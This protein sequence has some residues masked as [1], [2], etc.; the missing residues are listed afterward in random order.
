MKYTV[1]IPRELC[2][3]LEALMYEVNARK[4][5][6]AFMLDHDMGNSEAFQ[7][8][9]KEYVECYASYEIAKHEMAM[10]YITPKYP[11]GRWSVNFTNSTVEIDAQ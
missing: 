3:Y 9:Q 5:L 6:L 10:K 7:N 4:D 8:Y 11:N 2:D 1:T